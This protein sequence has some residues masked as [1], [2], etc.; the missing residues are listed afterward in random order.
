MSEPA[1]RATGKWRLSNIPKDS[2]KCIDIEDLGSSSATCEMC[3][4]Q[5]IRYVH[6]MQHPTYRSLLGCGCVCA[7][8]MEGNEEGA[9]RREASLRASA[10]R[11][12][13]WVTR[14]WR[15]SKEGNQYLNA[16]RYRAVVFPRA[17]GKWGCRVKA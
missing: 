2:W 6:Y 9:E 10:S 7:G 15:V 11:R 13:N 3:E 5:Y 8:H 4:S 14:E 16:D 12:L 17:N 1:L